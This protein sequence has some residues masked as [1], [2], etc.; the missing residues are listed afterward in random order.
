MAIIGTQIGSED[1]KNIN[2][3]HLGILKC[4]VKRDIIVA[5]VDIVIIIATPIEVAVETLTVPKTIIGI[6]QFTEVDQVIEI[7]IETVIE[8]VIVN[9]VSRMKTVPCHELN[10]SMELEGV[11]L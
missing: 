5:G 4:L 7:V 3:S 8:T 6:D 11:H 10:P 2:S 9:E 1:A